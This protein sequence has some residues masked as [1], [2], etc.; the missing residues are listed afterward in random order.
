MRLQLNAVLCFVIAAQDAVA[1]EKTGGL[2]A[3]KAGGSGKGLGA[4][5]T[6]KSGGGLARKA[7]GGKGLGISGTKKS[8]GL[9]GTKRGQGGAATQIARALRL[10][11]HKGTLT[12]QDDLLR[13]A[14]HLATPAHQIIFSTVTMDRPLHQ[15]LLFRQWAG[16]LRGRLANALVVG[17]NEHTCHIM[18]NESIPCFVDNLAPQLTGKQNFFGSQVLLK[19]WYARALLRHSLHIVF[20][21]PDIAW[22]RDPFA[23][24]DETYDLQGLSDIRSVN[25]TVQKHH[26]ITCIRPWMEQMYE[27][28]RRSIYPC[29]ST[30]LWFMRDTPQ[31]RAFL[32][33]MYGYLQARNNEWEQKAFQLLV[34]RYLIGIGDEL[35]PLRFRLLPTWGFINLEYYEERRKQGLDVS[36][37]VATHCGYLKN[38]ADKL[39]HL[40]LGGF[41]ERGLAWHQALVGTLRAIKSGNGSI[42]RDVPAL[43][44]PYVR[45]KPLSLRRKDHTI[46]NIVVRR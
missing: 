44:P 13:V 31:S 29:M 42:D 7:G 33:G 34:M 18:R 16:N 5:V 9:G 23:A 39:E 4:S 12:T 32:D 24:W 6:D 2:A 36:N 28:S 45:T 41:L 27:H 20:S 10:S 43:P 37:L 26:E 35:A 22:V 11:N 40:E 30:G 15:L 21:D 17:T 38:T 3:R 46:Y 8:G 14:T 19:W 25:L 1:A